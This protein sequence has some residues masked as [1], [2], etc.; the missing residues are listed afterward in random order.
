MFELQAPNQ[1]SF[2][3]IAPSEES[4][5]VWEFTHYHH[6]ASNSDVLDKEW[7]NSITKTIEVLISSGQCSSVLQGRNTGILVKFNSL[8]HV[9][10]YSLSFSD[11]SLCFLNSHIPSFFYEASEHYGL[12]A[13]KSNERKQQRS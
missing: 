4:K 1:S 13:Q 6:F 12:N 9:P 7:M 8:L 10:Y 11:L 5:Q 3:L 2:L